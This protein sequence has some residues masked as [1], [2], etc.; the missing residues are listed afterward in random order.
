[1]PF[2]MIQVNNSC[3]TEFL[4]IR[5]NRS[6][7]AIFAS[8][9]SKSRFTRIYET[10]FKKYL[11]NLNDMQV[12]KQWFIKYLLSKEIYCCAVNCIYLKIF[13]VALLTVFTFVLDYQKE[14]QWFWRMLQYKLP[15]KRMNSHTSKKIPSIS[16]SVSL[17]QTTTVT[18][19]VQH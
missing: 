14:S 9:Q 18:V 19:A 11:L 17:Q 1:M 15:H 8:K 13:I 16:K 5:K 10:L 2:E 3:R 4:K 7:Y 6:F 12:I